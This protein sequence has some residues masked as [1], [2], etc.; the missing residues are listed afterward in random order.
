M[1][2]WENHHSCSYDDGY[3]SAKLNSS[4]HHSWVLNSDCLVSMVHQHTHPACTSFP[5][6]FVFITHHHQPFTTSLN[7]TN[8]TRSIFLFLISVLLTSQSTP[9]SD[10][11]TMIDSNYSYGSQ[12]L[13]N[14]IL[15]GKAV[16]N[17]FDGSMV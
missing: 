17:V 14:L 7:P 9:R 10:N 1:D 12:E 2:T 15:T 4:C 16:S 3:T 6:D 13:V 11:V 5:L 8:P